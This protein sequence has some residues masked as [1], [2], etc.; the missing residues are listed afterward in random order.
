MPETPQPT[1]LLLGKVGQL[2]SEL[3]RLLVPVGTLHVLDY[4]DID[5]TQPDAVAEKV[6]QIR[7]TV[8]VNAV[9]YTN[10]DLAESQQE[11][12]DLVNHQAVVALAETAR[13]QNAA[14]IHVS[15]DYVFDGFKNSPYRED[16][17]TYPL[18]YYGASKLAA[19]IGIQESSAAYWIFRTAW[20]YSLTRDDFVRKVLQWSRSQ[21]QLKVVADQVGSPTWAHT[22]AAGICTALSQGANDPVEYI[23]QTSGIYHLAGDGA[24]SRLEWVRKILELDPQR[25]EQVTRELIPARTSDFPTPAQ[26]P[27]YTALDCSKYKDTFKLPLPSWEEA[28]AGAF[29]M[30]K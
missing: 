10:V 13:K 14:L 29:K 12:C 19:E 20:L 4:P 22:L 28:L 23:R 11:T 24:V 5:F 3:S 8:I 25:D 2:G 16:D 15:T 26:R 7:P 18:N 6:A 17:P 9:A 27:L 30:V 21:E 1:I